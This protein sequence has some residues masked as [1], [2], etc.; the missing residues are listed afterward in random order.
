MKRKE[1]LYENFK[2]HQDLIKFA[3]QKISS[4]LI[5]SG[6]LITSM[7]ASSYDLKFFTKLDAFESNNE[8]FFS[9][10]TFVMGIISYLLISILTIK[11]IWQILKP[12]K[13]INYKSD[14]ISLFYFEH[15]A[16]LDKAE[17][18]NLILSEKT[19]TLKEHVTSQVYE[20]ALILKKKNDSLR[21]IATLL[22]FCFLSVLLFILFQ[23]QL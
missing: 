21:S 9:I 10:S 7:L 8:L 20:L 4:V 14:E 13:A 15:I 11:V 1:F 16:R 19:E 6:I 5:I 18:S 3:D 2:N 17:F 22:V 23:S 12:R